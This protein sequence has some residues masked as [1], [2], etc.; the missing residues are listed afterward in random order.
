MRLTTN[1]TASFL[2]VSRIPNLLIIA[3]TQFNT[4]Y[5]L[6]GYDTSHLFTAH[7]GTFLLSTAMIGA[8]GYIINDYF[9]QKVDMINRPD[10]VLVGTKLRRRRALFFHG[11]LT[12]SGVYLGFLIN[13]FV[14]VIHIFSSGAL[15]TYSGILKRQLLIGTLTISFLTSLT[16]L[17]VLVYFRQFN[18]LVVA[19]AMFGCVTIFIRESLKDIIS[20]KG[21]SA[22]GYHSVPIVW[23]I[24]GTKILILLAGL[25]GVGLLVFYLFSIPSWA[26]RYFFVGVSIL[27]IWLFYRLIKAD[28]IKE[29]KQIKKTIDLVILLGLFSMALV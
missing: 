24:R 23:G 17:I 3:L 16:F 20:S 10:T 19:Y 6:L 8:G 2:L 21:E 14:G 25:A 22:F 9:D 12:L 7:F 28:Q 5:F 11:I 15:W 1:D 13:P 29:F 26:V 27:I 4:A 18:I